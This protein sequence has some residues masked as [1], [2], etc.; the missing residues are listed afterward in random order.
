[1]TV[2]DSSSSAAATALPPELSAAA[3]DRPLYPALVKGAAGRCPR[4]GEAPLYDGFLRIHDEC[5]VCGLALRE[6]RADDLPP[7]LTILIVGHLIVPGIAAMERLAPPPLWIG[8][9]FWSAMAIILCLIL[10]RP[11]KGAVIGMQWA[12]RM[13]GFGEEAADGPAAPDRVADPSADRS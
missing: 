5:G 3:A 11:V 12:W 1:M 13:H 10:L 4:C 8:F 6:H 2:S 7:Y 9:L